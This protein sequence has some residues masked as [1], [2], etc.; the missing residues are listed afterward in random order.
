MGA[1]RSAPIPRAGSSWGDIAPEL[2]AGVDVYKNQTAEMIEGG[3]AG[4]INLRTRVPFDQAGQT[5]EITAIGN[6]GDQRK[7][8][9][10]EISGLYSNRWTTGI[11]E[12]GL[13]LDGAFSKVATQS[14]GITYGRTAVFQDVYGPGMQ[15][16]PSSVGERISDYDRTRKGIAAA[17][18][19]RSLS[20]K[21]SATAGLQPLAISRDLARAWGHQ[22]PDRRI[23]LP[24]RFRVHD[25][26][27]VCV[28][29]TAAGT[30]NRAVHVRFLRQFPERHVGQPADRLLAGG[31]AGTSPTAPANMPARSR[32]TT[33]ASR[34]CTPATAGARRWVLRVTYRRVRCGCARTRPERG[35][36]VQRHATG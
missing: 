26:R 17:L 14:Q 33:R 27:T 9:T 24:R 35:D 3:I 31:E 34:C 5:I 25:R 36:A 10:P 6:Y 18:Q 28:E 21:L 1:I 29:N 23:R 11:G 13:L 4:S 2:M 19:W 7:K 30:G 12:V 16:I 32:S 8:I 15:F 20:G 22:L